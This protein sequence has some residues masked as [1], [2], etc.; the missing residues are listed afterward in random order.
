MQVGK[1]RAVAGKV[2]G[3]EQYTFRTRTAV[4]G[5]RGTDTGA[6]CLVDPATKKLFEFLDPLVTGSQ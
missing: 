5:I 2:S 3:D 1:F 4:C 6:E